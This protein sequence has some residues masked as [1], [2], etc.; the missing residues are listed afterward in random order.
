MTL[1]TSS[2]S[3]NIRGLSSGTTITVTAIAGGAYADSDAIP[4]KVLGA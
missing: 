2:T 4:I 3:V 1:Y